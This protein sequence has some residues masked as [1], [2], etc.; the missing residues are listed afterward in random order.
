MAYSIGTATSPTDL[1]QKIATWLATQGWTQDLSAAES[2][3]WRAHF[4]KGST[5]VNLRAMLNGGASLSLNVG[6]GFSGVASWV[7]QPGVP[8]INGTGPACYAGL[9]MLANGTSTSYR[10]FHDGADNF[11]VVLERAPSVFGYI[12]WGISLAKFGTWTGGAYFFGSKS[13]YW[14]NNSGQ[15]DE[16]A[17]F[18]SFC[19]GC[20]GVNQN[21]ATYVRAD[22]DS[23]TGAAAWVGIC[24][25]ATY[26]NNF[27]YPGRNGFSSVPGGSSM[28]NSIAHYVS[29]DARQFSVMNSQANLLPVLLHVVRDGGGISPLGNIPNVFYSNA[30]GHG[31]GI[32]DTFTIG[33]DTYMLFPNFAV[34]KV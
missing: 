6:T 20:N 31:Y 8:L 3:G 4:H 33:A 9:N 27:G 1:L 14:A 23:T 11:V 18:T 7:D 12:G 25:M 32:G 16:G 13:A 10:F 24:V 15:T 19:P 34:K 2:D 30:T 5:Y 21:A 29:F 17:L 22:V 28:D 26:N